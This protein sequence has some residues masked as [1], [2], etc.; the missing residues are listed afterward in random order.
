MSFRIVS[1]IRSAR[2]ACGPENGYL[3]IRRDLTCRVQTGPIVLPRERSVN[4]EQAAW[5]NLYVWCVQKRDAE[6]GDLCYNVSSGYGI[7]TQLNASIG[8]E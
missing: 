3:G 7:P 1:S 8:D 4:G 5:N 2:S 6:N